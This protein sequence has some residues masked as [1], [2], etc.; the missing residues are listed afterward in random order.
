MGHGV[1]RMRPELRIKSRAVQ[2]RI[3]L[4]Y[5]LG[6]YEASIERFSIV[7][8]GDTGTLTNYRLRK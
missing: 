5:G 2:G 4:D 3:P 7:G 8:S 1:G 6:E